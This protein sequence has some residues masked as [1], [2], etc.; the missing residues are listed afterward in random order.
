[1]RKYSK[2]ASVSFLLPSNMGGGIPASSLLDMGGSVLM[3]MA[4]T[5]VNGSDGVCIAGWNCCDWL[6]MCMSCVEKVGGFTT[7]EACTIYGPGPAD[8]FK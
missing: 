6:C 2:N 5:G 4:D 1:M 7:I 8:I 3:A